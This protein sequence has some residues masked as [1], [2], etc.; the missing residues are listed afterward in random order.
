MGQKKIGLDEMFP[1]WREPIVGNSKNY[2]HSFIDV[3]DL[4]MAKG[5][6]FR[7]TRKPEKKMA[8]KGIGAGYK[9]K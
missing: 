9:V 2:A 6:G 5:H 3:R 1:S 4:E 7:F 8:K